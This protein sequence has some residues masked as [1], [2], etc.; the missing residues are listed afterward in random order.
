[1]PN[2]Y[3]G[4]SLGG[5]NP[6]LVLATTHP[7]WAATINSKPLV[8]N[9]IPGSAPLAPGANLTLAVTGGTASTSNPSADMNRKVVGQVPGGSVAFSNP[10]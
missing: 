4:P 3:I 8:N 7:D 6:D 1:M 2:P 5:S 10:A 9:A